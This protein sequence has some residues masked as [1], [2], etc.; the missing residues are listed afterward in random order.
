MLEANDDR[1]RSG[2]L[3]ALPFCFYQVVVGNTLPAVGS[4]DV[5]LRS[6]NNTTATKHHAIETALL[7]E[8]R[9]GLLSAGDR[10]A[11][12]RAVSQ[13]YGVSMPTA[14][15]AIASLT[16]KGYL[17]R[18]E[19]QGT[20][21]RKIPEETE[22]PKQLIEALEAYKA[23]SEPAR[24]SAFFMP[25]ASGSARTAVVPRRNVLRL[26]E[27]IQARKA[28]VTVGGAPTFVMS[29]GGVPL[30]V[31]VERVKPGVFH[32][33]NHP[34]MVAPLEWTIK[35]EDFVKI[36]GLVERVRPLREVLDEINRLRSG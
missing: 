35:F 18:K 2:T 34:A 9:A 20:F 19:R 1:S 30:M 24:V 27:A 7:A 25:C 10:F 33:T 16:A 14:D 17:E 4:G 6:E 12:V 13:K 5:A 3:V 29:G 11:S 36:G 22:T 15:K 23:C 8:I 26:N 28:C 31:D 32:W 21:V